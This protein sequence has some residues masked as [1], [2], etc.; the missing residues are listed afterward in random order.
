MVGCDEEWN[1]DDAADADAAAA[2]GPLVPGGEEDDA[3]APPAGGGAAPKVPYDFTKWELPRVV[4]GT[5]LSF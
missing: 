1:F 4:L 5:R 3:G 2:P